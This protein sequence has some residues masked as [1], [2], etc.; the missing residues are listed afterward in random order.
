[1]NALEKDAYTVEELNAALDAQGTTLK[2][3]TILLVRTGWMEGICC[4]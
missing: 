4:R 3:G 1:M 2:P